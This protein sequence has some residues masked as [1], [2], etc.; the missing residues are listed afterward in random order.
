MFVDLERP[1]NSNPGI[2]VE[3]RACGDRPLKPWESR[4]IL[5]GTCSCRLVIPIPLLHLYADHTT[6]NPIWPKE[7]LA[8]FKCEKSKAKPKEAKGN[9]KSKKEKKKR[10]RLSRTVIKYVK[11]TSSTHDPEK[12]LGKQR[13]EKER[14]DWLALSP[15]WRPNRVGEV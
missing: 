7:N 4:S 11:V 6:H 5:W 12:P 3:A 10:N 13:P 8:S 15:E 14:W 1:I 9:W 2:K